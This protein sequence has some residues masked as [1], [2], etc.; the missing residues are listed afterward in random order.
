MKKDVFESE[1]F[2]K[3]A[4]TPGVAPLRLPVEDAGFGDGVTVVTEDG[5]IRSIATTGA[6]I[7]NKSMSF[8]MAKALTKAH[9]DTLDQLKAIL[10]TK[11]P[12]ISSLTR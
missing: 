11:L 9:I 12:W 8:E 5:I 2:Q 3:Y 4:T 7:V 10:Q 1:Q 6:D